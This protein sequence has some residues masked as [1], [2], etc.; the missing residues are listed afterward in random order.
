MMKKIFP[1]SFLMCGLL[2]SSFALQANDK[3]ETIYDAQ[4]FQQVCKGKTQGDQVSFAF[5]GI[6]WNGTC[7]PQFFASSR[8]AAI[9]GDEAELN[10]VCQ[11]DSNTKS[12]NIEGQE[13]KGKCA[14][15]FVPPQPKS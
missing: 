5:R 13:I 15:G 4:K 8:K 10:S 6:I 7:E 3:V 9:K 12:I 14:L 1:V 11:S 2:F